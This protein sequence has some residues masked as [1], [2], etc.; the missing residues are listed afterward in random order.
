[1]AKDSGRNDGLTLYWPFVVGGFVGPVAAAV[2]SRW[3][4]RHFGFGLAMF[5][6]FGL[7]SWTVHRLST[8]RDQSPR[9][10]VAGSVLAALAA[11]VTAGLMAYL[12]PW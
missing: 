9:R 11:G 4:P 7:A 2:L 12:L 10:A 1:M 8:R 6:A 3:M 5:L